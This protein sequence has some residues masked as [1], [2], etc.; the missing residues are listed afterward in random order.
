M[1]YIIRTW[2]R[3]KLTEAQ[4]PSILAAINFSFIFINHRQP[5]EG[6]I[7]YRRGFA[8][9]AFFPRFLCARGQNSQ[10]VCGGSLL[11][12]A[13]SFASFITILLAPASSN[14]TTGPHH[15]ANPPPTHNVRNPIF[16]GYPPFP[17]RAILGPGFPTQRT[18][19]SERH[20]SSV[21]FSLSFLSTKREPH[22]RSPT[23][24]VVGQISR[25]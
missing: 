7:F 20:A 15:A 19:A 16:A 3:A 10:T 18:L 25:A 1:I 12:R 17:H 8:R 13:P 5:S 24:E 6:R 14:K 11:P 23:D 22:G 4:I 9:D 2:I 21:S